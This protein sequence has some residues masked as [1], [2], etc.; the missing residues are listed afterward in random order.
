MIGQQ[1]FLPKIVKK[2][3]VPS[4]FEMSYKQDKVPLS[5]PSEGEPQINGF[6]LFLVTLLSDFCPKVLKIEGLHLSLQNFPFE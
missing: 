6:E 1:N 2:V 4:K 3:L 5:S